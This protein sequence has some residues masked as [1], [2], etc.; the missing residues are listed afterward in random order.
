VHHT[1]LQDSESYTTG[2]TADDGGLTTKEAEAGNAGEMSTI[3]DSMGNDG[4]S[5]PIP[6]S[7]IRNQVDDDSVAANQVGSTFPFL[8][9]G[10]T[11]CLG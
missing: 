4:M 8:V 2:L 9:G 7:N 5:Q 11:F 6:L 1:L 10:V 3:P